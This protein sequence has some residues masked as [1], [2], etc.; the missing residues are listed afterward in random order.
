MKV[1]KKYGEMFLLPSIF[2]LTNLFFGFLSIH[3]SFHGRF[4][5]AAFWII[6]AAFMDGFDGIVA[7][8]TK[9]QSDF[10]MSWTPW[11]MPSRSEWPLR[12]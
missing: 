5:W 11:R 4:R 3:M 6:V 2:S 10:G 12:S 8:A 7:R 1:K 9:T